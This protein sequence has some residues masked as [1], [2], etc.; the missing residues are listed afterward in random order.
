M[1]DAAF[2]SSKFSAALPYA[3]YVAT[4]TADQQEKW[5]SAAANIRLDESQVALAS[6]FT[7]RINVLV[8]SGIWCGDCSAQCPILERIAA[9]NRAGVDLRFVDRD[10]NLD[11]AEGLKIC[12]GLRVP[13]A[14]FM[15]EEFDFVSLLG[16]RTLAR[17]R[18]IAAKKL[19]PH[20]PLPGAGEA[21]DVLAA[22]VGDW[23]NEFE[24][25]HLVL[26]LSPKLRAK[27]N[28]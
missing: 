9:C 3:A 11:L 23:L 28:D 12:G 25:V 24:R 21:E 10:Q 6:G 19:G 2:L 8:S 17:Y 15:N 14:V 20:C 27:H 1:L 4:G 18:H 7:R 22:T 13:T 26:R 5:R 16:D